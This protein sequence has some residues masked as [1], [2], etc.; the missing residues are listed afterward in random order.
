MHTG[1]RHRVAHLND[2]VKC[3]SRLGV[4]NHCR[5]RIHAQLVSQLGEAA[6]EEFLIREAEDR[7]ETVF[8]ARERVRAG[9]IYVQRDGSNYRGN[10]PEQNFAFGFIAILSAYSTRTPQIKPD[11]SVSVNTTLAN[12]RPS[13]TYRRSSNQS[14]ISR[15]NNPPPRAIVRRRWD[16]VWACVC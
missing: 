15:K 4:D 8:G 14:N 2:V 11:Q 6:V 9:P 3:S 1:Y 12:Q 10:A 7:A 13:A 5:V 16:A